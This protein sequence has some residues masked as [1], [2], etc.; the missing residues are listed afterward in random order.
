MEMS[1]AQ[2]YGAIGTAIVA[3]AGI[4]GAT[5][6][7]SVKI[8]DGAVAAFRERI[9]KALDENTA[10]NRERVAEEQVS[11]RRFAVL[12]EK[13]GAIRDWVHDHSDHTPVRGVP[14]FEPDELALDDHPSQRRRVD[15][16]SERR[17]ARP[18]NGHAI[19][20]P[21]DPSVPYYYGRPRR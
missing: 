6:R 18:L 20:P 2:I 10:S 19:D 15:P 3:A 7:W 11:V 9:G 12:E 5:I 17:R 14:T 21:A 13:I 16:L 8:I 1:E 4:L